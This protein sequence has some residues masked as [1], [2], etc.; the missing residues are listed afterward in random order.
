MLKGIKL[1][2]N[3]KTQIRKVL[4]QGHIIIEVNNLTYFIQEQPILEMLGKWKYIKQ[5]VETIP[6]IPYEALF[7]SNVQFT[8]E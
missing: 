4:F 3:F 6:V 7:G 8:R 5:A 1:E 2:D